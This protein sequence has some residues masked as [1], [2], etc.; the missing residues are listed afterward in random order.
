MTEPQNTGKLLAE[1][2]AL[3]QGDRVA[4]VRSAGPPDEVLGRL[5]AEAEQLA[6]TDAGR[7]LDATEC[8]IAVSEAIGSPLGRSLVLRARG[9]AL[10]HVGRLEEGWLSCDAAAQLAE[11]AGRPVESGL[12]RLRSMQALGELGRFDDSIAA[13]EAA[14][15]AFDRAGEDKLKARSEVNLGVIFQRRDDPAR[16]MQY[17]DGARPRLGDTPMALGTVDN[18]RGEALLALNDFAGAG[19]AFRSALEHCERAEADLSA[20]VVEGNLADLASRQGQLHRAVYHFEC[21]RRRLETTGSSGHLSR[22]L[23]EQA[24]AVSV[25][26]LPADALGLYEEA[27]PQL[28]RAGQALEAARA[29]AGLGCTLV[30]LARFSDARTALAAAARAFD[31][32]GHGTARARVDL[33]RAELCAANDLPDESRRLIHSALA[34]LHDRP[35]EAA[36][37][38]HLLARLAMADNALDLAEAELTAALALARRLDLAPLLADVLH[39]FGRLRR[40]QG[41]LTAAVGNLQSATTQIER[42]RGTLNAQRFRG[43]YL[44]DRLAVY[45]DLITALLDQGEVEQ[46]ERAFAVAEQAKSRLLLEQVSGEI[47]MAPENALSADPSEQRLVDEHADLRGR[48]NA[49]YSRLGDDDLAGVSGAWQKSLIDLERRLEEMESRLTTTRGA[50][51]LY[52]RSIDLEGATAALPPAT[53]LLEYVIAN[54]EV[55]AFVVG[56]EGDTAVCR[57][58]ATTGVLDDAMARLQFQINRA[59]RPGAHDGWRGERMLADIR[60]ELR[61]LDRLLFEPLRPLIAAD[62]RLLIVPHGALHLLPFHAL[63]DG[64]RHL[65]ETREVHYCPSASLYAQLGTGRRPAERRAVVVGVADSTAPNIESEAERV[66]GTLGVA[67]EDILIGDAAT[68]DRFEERSRGAAMLHLACHA[69]FAPGTPF[70]SGLRLADRW[71]TVRDIYAMRLEAELVTLSGC[72]TGRSQVRGGDELV[73][74]LRGFFA[75]GVSTLLL[76]LWRVDDESAADTMAAFYELWPNSDATTKAAALREAQLAGLARR[77]HP[78]FWA[79]FQLVGKP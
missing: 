66:A 6:I 64:E 75:A 78:A 41:D 62:S 9:S 68:V 28:D 54:D 30:R 38:R 36:A 52:A 26:G 55:L 33:I 73:G 51:G 65:V 48:L 76:S 18:N 57:R 10:C 69:R 40:R 72:E 32:L 22:L 61:G 74:L 31:E 35:I 25:L 45:D 13:G 16:A 1:L 3:E 29:R 34:V 77:P 63:W 60:A 58:L 50:A 44:S 47:D 67:S 4:R 24:E 70:G 2:H 59:L 21:A 19:A 11:D 15:A 5:A 56:K 49:M 20:A 27:L 79:P 14:R 23:T 43:A 71:L 8:L 17:F 7:A 42:V 46:T 39:T 12:A 53:T 37:A